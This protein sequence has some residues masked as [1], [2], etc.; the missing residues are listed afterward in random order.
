MP[1]ICP[2]CRNPIELTETATDG[3]ILCPLCGASF[4]LESQS[5]THWSMLSGRKIGRFELLDTVGHGAFGTVYK[6]RD[7]EL[8]RP[9]ALK[10]PRAG[11]F[12]TPED[13]DRFLR[14]ARSA[15]Q[16]QHPAIVTVHEVGVATGLPYLVS[17]FVEGITLADLLTSRQLSI[18]E[19]AQLIAQVAD[20]LHYA[21]E[22]GVVHRDVKPSNIMLRQQGSGK[23]L[24]AQT[25]SL[26]LEPLLMD[27]GLAKRDTGEITMTMDGQVLGTPAYMSPEQASGEAHKVDGRS[28]LYSLGVVLYQLLTGALPFRGNKRMLLYQVLHEDPRPPRTLNDHIPRDLQT[29]CL[30]AMSKEVERR[31]ATAGDFRDDLRHFLSHEPIKARPVGR[32]EKLWRWCRRNPSKVWLGVLVMVLVAGLLGGAGWY[33]QDRADRAIE[34]ATQ[35]AHQ[36]R[37]QAE[38]DTHKYYSLVAEVG[39]RV[40]NPQM[41]WTW[42]GLQAL[43]TASKLSVDARD[44]LKLRRLAVECMAG[45]DL[46]KVGELAKGIEAYCLAYSPD[47]KRL[48][49]AQHQG[50]FIPGGCKV[51]VY[52]V[53]DLKQVREYRTTPLVKLKDT[54]VH[55]LVFSPDNRWLVAGTRSGE[56]NIWDTENHNIAEPIVRK[57]HQGTVTGLAFRPDGKTLFSCSR[58]KSLKRWS[59]QDW[60]QEGDPQIFD[61]SCEVVACHPQG[62]MLGCGTSNAYNVFEMRSVEAGEVPCKIHNR[63]RGSVFCPKLAF[64]RNGNILA[65]CRAHD[66][67]L[68]STRCST[69]TPHLPL[70]ESLTGPYLSSSHQGQIAHLEFNADDSL[71]V[72]SAGDRFVKLWEMASGRL[73]AKLFVGGTGNVFAAFDP[74]GRYLAVTEESRTVVYEIGGL[75]EQQ[76]VAPIS[77]PIRAIAF[78]RDGQ[79]LA[80]AAYG[81]SFERWN[82]GFRHEFWLW[83]RKNGRFQW[84]D[85]NH[86]S[87]R[88]DDPDRASVAFH[89]QAG[90]VVHTADAVKPFWVW[91]GGKPQERPEGGKQALFCLSFARDGK[92][93]WGAGHKNEVVALCWPDQKPGFV[94]RNPLVD[95]KLGLGRGNRGINAVCAGGVWVLAGSQDSTTSLLRIKGGGRERY[96][97]NPGGPVISVALSADDSLA[98]SGT[99]KGLVLI[100]R[101]PSGEPLAELKAHRDVV[102]SVAFSPDGKLLATGSRDKTVRLWQHSRGTFLELVALPSPGPVIQLCFTPDSSK[103]AMVVANEC[104]VRVWDLDQLQARLTKMALGW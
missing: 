32:V 3:E 55:S 23:P 57:A 47:G 83:Q 10:V 71:L 39:E 59:T 25:A 11:Q 5:T 77:A 22:R 102:Q 91:R 58:D 33:M 45:V 38:S 69:D 81:S 73:V 76:L 72:S 68:I 20:A 79:T 43:E 31:Y 80:C 78:S 44:K 7:P 93:L 101:V 26:S 18:P 27:F 104:A 35:L 36:V 28:D 96:W 64:S 95:L 34:K 56:I 29:I 2:H 85:A 13:L 19:S 37:L 30:K 90:V 70:R 61:A 88:S 41:G 65:Y 75:R 12:A 74:T 14:E 67:V 40:A 89:P 53:S 8:D 62:T 63:L 17:D 54:Y 84:I 92:T 51:Q 103:L 52:Q 6:A 15:A 94:W 100:V 49:I 24:A 42:Q 9:V 86:W 97:A 60:R 87:D 99:Q 66:I 48:A 46:R 21:H 50:L 98:A 16:L 1:I 82:Y 4:R